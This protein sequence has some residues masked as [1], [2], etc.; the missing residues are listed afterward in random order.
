MLI[1]PILE[2]LFKTKQ[3]E[4]H[5]QPFALDFDV[6]KNNAYYYVSNHIEQNGS[7]QTL[8][9]LGIYLV[10]MT[11]FKTAV[12]YLASYFIIPLRTGLVRDL[13]NQMYDKITCLNIGFF[14]KQKKGDIMSR[15]TSDVTEVEASIMSS[16]ELLFK[17]PIMIIIYLSMM[18]VLSWQLTLFVLIVLP[19]AGFIMGRVGRSLKKKSKLAQ[20]QAGQLLAQI[21]ETLGGL[22][23]VKAFNA[24]KKVITRFRIMNET[25]RRTINRV[26]R[27]LVLAHPMSEFLGTTTIAIVLFFGGT[28]ILNDNSPLTAAEFIGYL[29]IFY[30]MINP[31]K[32]LSKALYSIQ[33]GKASLERIDTILNATN[34]LE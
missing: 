20:Q 24:E 26:N 28:L 7:T 9:L 27:R 14:K 29:V 8:M 22:R 3:L 31:A 1:I 15:M 4:Y 11:F 34:P 12:A 17:N 18:L 32:D 21:D 6:I 23:V 10:V 33:K 30:S 25:L 2:I 5:L 16:V 19:V 13:R